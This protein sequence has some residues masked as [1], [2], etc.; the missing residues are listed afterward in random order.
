MKELIIYLIC[1][2][3]VILII[4]LIQNNIKHKKEIKEIQKE[5]EDKEAGF[6]FLF[7]LLH[8]IPSF[9]TLN[10]VNSDLIHNLESS[11]VESYLNHFFHGG[12]RAA[13]ILGEYLLEIEGSTTSQAKKGMINICLFKA[14][15]KTEPK[16]LADIVMQQLFR[17][18]VEHS[19][20]SE[21]ANFA[22][23][24]EDFIIKTLPTDMAG[25]FIH[26]LET[27]VPLIVKQNVVCQED[28]EALRA[29]VLL[30]KRKTGV[31]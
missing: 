9:N 29:R 11:L 20:D 5:L 7:E 10:K 23:L 30:I 24:T 1:L 17:E 31:K 27:E 18:E 8:G 28:S 4:V 6:C 21:L 26:E 15:R 25:A 3:V 14:V 22:K 16:H 13:Y 12:D 19:F 2:S